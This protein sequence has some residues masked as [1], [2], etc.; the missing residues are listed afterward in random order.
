MPPAGV[1]PL[2]DVPSIRLTISVTANPLDCSGST[3]TASELP[4]SSSPASDGISKGL[5]VVDCR[6][7]HRVDRILAVIRG[8]AFL[9]VAS[10]RMLDILANGDTA[11]FVDQAVTPGMVRRQPAIDQRWH[12]GCQRSHERP[13]FFGCRA[14]FGAE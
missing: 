13:D 8:R 3:S 9:G 4:M 6:A 7:E 10:Q 14:P 12:I 1:P 5:L 11:A 2:A